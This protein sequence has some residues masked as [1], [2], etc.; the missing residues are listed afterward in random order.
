M[1]ATAEAPQGQKL[2]INDARL[3]LLVSQAALELDRAAKDNATSLSHANDF[4][5][6][7]RESL[8]VDAGERTSHW[9]DPDTV[10]VFEHA[11]RNSGKAQE[12]RTV[13]DVIR[14]A[15]QFVG[16]ISEK[17]ERGSELDKEDLLRFCVAFGNGLLAH[18]AQYRPEFPANPYRR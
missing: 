12:L 6:F 3:P 5:V 15:L 2:G 17:I 4:F 10:D 8:E 16:G 7:L 1:T 13:Q 14:E 18:R 11:L 9:L